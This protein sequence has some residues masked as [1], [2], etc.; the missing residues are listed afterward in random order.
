MRALAVVVATLLSAATAGCASNPE[1]PQPA[2]RDCKPTAKTL[3]YRALSCDGVLLGGHCY[4]W[5]IG[6]ECA[7]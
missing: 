7:L 3:S 1:K 4:T 6:T 5:I 2:K